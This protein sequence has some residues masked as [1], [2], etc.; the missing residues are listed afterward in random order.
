MPVIID[1]ENRAAATLAINLMK[2]SSKLTEELAIGT[3]WQAYRL[4]DALKFRG[5][6]YQEEVRN[7][8]R[9]IRSGKLERIEP[10]AKVMLRAH[11]LLGL[12]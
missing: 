11:E 3:A 8:I 2:D 6:R 10:N 5:E 9:D 1:F 12:K 7:A 4:S